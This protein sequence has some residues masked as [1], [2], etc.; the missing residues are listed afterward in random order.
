MNKLSFDYFPLW[1]SS[2]YINIYYTTLGRMLYT[3]RLIQFLTIL[4]VYYT[5]PNTKQILK[6][7]WESAR[8]KRQV[9]PKKKFY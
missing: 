4:P 3:I 9:K 6:H 2:P 5:L 8:K 1:G 7:N